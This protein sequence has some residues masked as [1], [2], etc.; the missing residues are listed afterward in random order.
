MT[1]L[2]IDYDSAWKGALQTYF[3]D[4]IH[5]FVPHVHADIDWSRGCEFLDQELS[6]VVQKARLG[7]RRVDKLVRLW[8]KDGIETW[9]LVHVEIQ[10]QRD[11]KFAERMFVYH[12]RVFDRFGRQPYSIAVLG[13]R[14]PK[15]RPDRFGADIWD[16][17]AGIRFP[18]IKLSDYRQRWDMLESST[19][20]FAIVV[21][22][23]LKTQDTQQ[24]PEDRYRWKWAF[25]RRLYAMGFSR[26]DII[27]LYTFVDLLMAL[28]EPLEERYLDELEAYE[29]GL[30]MPY[31]TSA[32]RI[33]IKRGIKIGKEEGRA[34]GL[35]Q[36]LEQG[37][38]EGERKGLLTAIELALQIKFG[39]DG[40]AFAPAVR[41]VVSMERLQQIYIRLIAGA[42]L[43]ELRYLCTEA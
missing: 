2:R 10:S 4:F 39:A 42:G 31:I 14:S 13:D 16:C 6:Q 7:K 23:H 22:A 18:V 24:D 27:G 1:K 3:P 34:E 12:Y 17:F 11:A 8:R 43:D 19:N 28:P 30:Q 36:D 21:M 25:T 38:E 41:Q 33:G 15:W 40:E 29:E 37:R 32:E 20:P 35:E 9:V 26:D 5:F